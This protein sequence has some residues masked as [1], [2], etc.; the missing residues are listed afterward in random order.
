MPERSIQENMM[1]REMEREVYE[2]N[3][4]SEEVDMIERHRK[5]KTLARNLWD[6]LDEVY[7]R[8]QIKTEVGRIEKERDSG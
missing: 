1:H 8:G 5:A 4:L 2:Y 6:E 3:T 7:S